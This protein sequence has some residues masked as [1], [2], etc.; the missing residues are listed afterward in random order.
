MFSKFGTFDSAQGPR[1]ITIAIL[2]ARILRNQLKTTQH[3]LPF[4]SFIFLEKFEKLK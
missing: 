2:K 1:V 4:S 3:R